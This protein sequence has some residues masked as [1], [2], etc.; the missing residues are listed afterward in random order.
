MLARI[1]LS[2][3]PWSFTMTSGV[4]ISALTLASYYGYQLDV[5]LAMLALVGAVLLHAFVNWFNDYWDYVVGV[6]R[7]GVGTTIYRPHA[8]IEGVME[9]RRL[10]TLG[11][12]LAAVSTLIGLYIALNGRPL[13]LPIG[14]AGLL[15]GFLYSLPRVGFKYNALGEPVVF[16]AFG[17]LMFLGSFYAATGS[18]DLRALV[19]SAPLGMLITAVLLAN[20]IRDVESDSKSGIKTLA[21]I[22][23]PRGS[24]IL[25]STLML[26]SIA[27]TLTLIALRALPIT[28]IITILILPQVAN[29]T[30]VSLRGEIPVDFDPR[31]A[32]I[33][34]L[35]SVL[36]IASLLAATIPGW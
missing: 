33:V 8:L 19:T 23:G 3:R 24:T 32:R 22:L 11:F 6:D 27:Y 4:V 30:R 13:V 18:L 28:S 5:T 14:V 20:N 7:V 2:V 34:I 29:L 26:G 16:I 10:L 9:P 12:S 25:Y 1:I 21:I 31:T 35:Y 15:V 36:L 17:P